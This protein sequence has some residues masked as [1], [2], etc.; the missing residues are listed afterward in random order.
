MNRLGSKVKQ[1]KFLEFKKMYPPFYRDM[2]TDLCLEEVA[3][4]WEWCFDSNKCYVLEKLDGTNVKLEIANGNMTVGV[5]NQTSKGYIE[6]NLNTPEHKYIMQGVANAIAKRKKKFS[7]GTHFGEVIG[8]KYQGNPYKMDGHLW[9]TFTPYS[10]GV[11]AYKDY[12]K[13]SEFEE[14]K[15]WILNLKSLHN[16]NA[17]A[18]GVIFLNKETGEMAKLR[19]DMFDVKYQPKRNKNNRRS[20]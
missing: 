7:D 9:V 11:Q 2:E 16:P 1:E 17:E 18:E 15:E 8:E 5:R 13:S 19:K 4:G 20:Q 3:I 14:W 10:D 6:G 12:P